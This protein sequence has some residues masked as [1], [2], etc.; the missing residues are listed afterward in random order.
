MTRDP[1]DMVS[2][3][4]HKFYAPKGIGAL[5]IREG[6]EIAPLILGGGQERGRR[7]GTEN[8]ALAAGLARALDLAVTEQKEEAI[9]IRTGE[10]GPDAV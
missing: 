4:G 1:F 9:R 2:I 8:V 6:L 3:V 10:R 5:Y 7:P